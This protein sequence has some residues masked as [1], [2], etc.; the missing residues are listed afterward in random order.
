M[1]QRLETLSGGSVTI[2]IYPRSVL[3]SEV[4]CTEQLKPG[5]TRILRTFD[6]QEVEGASWTEIGDEE[7]KRFAGTARYAIEVTN[8][9]ANRIRDLDIRK[10]KWKIFHEI[11]IVTQLY[12][13]FD[14]WKSTW[15]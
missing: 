10:V 5:E 1:K 6:S 9:S 11:N 13:K 12:K 8:L 3:G 15:S 7:A 2:D 14:A 4:Q